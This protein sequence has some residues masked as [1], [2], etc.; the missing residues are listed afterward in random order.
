MRDNFRAPNREGFDRNGFQ[1]CSHPGVNGKILLAVTS[2]RRS[3]LRVAML[4]D[5]SDY[6][7]RLLLDKH[8]DDFNFRWESKLID[9]PLVSFGFISLAVTLFAYIS[10]SA[11]LEMLIRMP[12]MRSSLITYAQKPRLERITET[13]KKYDAAKTSKS[14]DFNAKPEVGSLQRL[15]LFYQFCCALNIFVGPGGLFNAVIMALLC[16]YFDIMAA[17][18]TNQ[19]I[20]YDPSNK[21]FNH[22]N[23]WYGH[24]FSNLP[25]PHAQYIVQFILLALVADFG[26]YWGHRIQHESS[27]LWKNFHYRHHQLDT[28]TPVGTSSVYTFDY[29]IKSRYILMMA[30]TMSSA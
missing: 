12:F 9:T 10:T 19:T 17:S 7:G 6:V 2:T 29:L 8:W 16:G 5:V 13:R 4:S 21:G 27:W 25:F 18:G 11:I 22:H 26:L 20:V 24:L 1:V 15:T 3:Q 23:W 28:P 14:K 30:R